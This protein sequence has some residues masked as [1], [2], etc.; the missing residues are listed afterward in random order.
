[1]CLSVTKILNYYKIFKILITN[2]YLNRE[3]DFFKFKILFF[4]DLKY[5]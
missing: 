3:V 2:K 1:M 4:K 5:Y